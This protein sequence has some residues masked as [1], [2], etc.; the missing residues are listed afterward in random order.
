MSGTA[1]FQP[2]STPYEVKAKDFP[3]HGPF[4]DRC[5]FILRF[6][7]LAPSTHNTQPWK[8]AL[9]PD[10]IGVFA[11]YGRRLPTVDPHNR[12]L[13]MSVGAA[14]YTIRVAANRFGLPAQVRY[15]YSGDSEQPLAVVRLESH[16]RRPVDEEMLTLFPEIIQ[17]H[18]NRK[19][20]LHSRI[21]ASVLDLVRG[22]RMGSGA[23][24]MVSTDGRLNEQVADMVAAAERLQFSN[25]SFRA[26]WG[27]WVRGADSGEVD[28]IPGDALGL[29]AFSTLLAPWAVRTFHL[30]NHQAAKDRNLCVEAPALVVVTGDDIVPHWL[31]AGEL[32]QK[33]LLTLTREGLHQSYFNMPVHV[34]ELRERLRALLGMPG[35]PQAILRVGYCLAAP[36]LTPRRP[37][38]DVIIPS[39]DAP[40]G[41]HVDEQ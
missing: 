18:T 33:L 11:D 31:E 41:L 32:L 10:G 27:A 25:P 24:V 22:M 28:G 30:G 6:A 5:E 17:R 12:E 8:F 38:R 20:F 15:N 29:N 36:V 35:L 4:R 3:V 14:V 34:P 2:A 13:L 26:D 21:P 23:A 9:T 7:V 19:P 1:I 16:E 39:V 40:G 37:L